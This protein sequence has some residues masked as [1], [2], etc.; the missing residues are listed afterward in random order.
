M[1]LN[2][3]FHTLW[4]LPHIVESAV[5][6][7]TNYTLVDRGGFKHQS[8]RGSTMIQYLLAVVLKGS[9]SFFA[10]INNNTPYYIQFP[11]KKWVHKN[12]RNDRFG[13]PG[14]FP[15]PLVLNKYEFFT[16]NNGNFAFQAT[17]YNK[18]CKKV[19]ILEAPLQSSQYS[20]P[21][22]T[23]VPLSRDV[24]NPMSFSSAAGTPYQE[25]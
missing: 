16:T 20:S 19:G 23:N 25:N 10:A 15:W 12:K 11:I 9:T 3:E 13:H 24:C 22:R 5:S 8:K 1:T 17:K 21:N 18:K 14:S 2:T 4:L 7:L 6:N